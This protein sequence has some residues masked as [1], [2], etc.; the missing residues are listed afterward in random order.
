MTTLS[1]T[2]PEDHQTIGTE[3]KI[4]GNLTTVWILESSEELGVDC[5]GHKDTGELHLGDAG[6]VEALQD[7]G[8]L[9]LLHVGDLAVSN[10][11]PGR[12]LITGGTREETVRLPE[13]EDLLRQ[14]AVGLLVLPEGFEHSGADVG[15]DLL[16]RLMQ[17]AA[18]GEPGNT[19]DDEEENQP[20]NH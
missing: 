7:L 9:V 20:I 3:Q 11:I 15:G 2:V 18:A 16:A 1:T 13:H 5:L 17:G 10:T 4:I 8:H 6:L 14:V 19:R 12:K